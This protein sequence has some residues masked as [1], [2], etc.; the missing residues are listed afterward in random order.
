LISVVKLD[1]RS[2]KDPESKVKAEAELEW[3]DRP[4][5]RLEFTLQP[6]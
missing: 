1:Y 4:V 6:M 5:A 3:L 2:T